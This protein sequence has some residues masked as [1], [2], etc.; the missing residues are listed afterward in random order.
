MDA[1]TAFA[2]HFSRTDLGGIFV[3]HAVFPVTGDT[4]RIASCDGSLTN[5]AGNAKTPR[6]FLLTA[7]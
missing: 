6:I 2:S 1:G 4:S 3:L 7:N 5:P